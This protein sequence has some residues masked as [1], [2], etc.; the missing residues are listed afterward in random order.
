MKEG[1]LLLYPEKQMH[2]NFLRSAFLLL[3]SQRIFTGNSIDQRGGTADGLLI[4]LLETL[5]FIQ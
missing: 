3:K 5:F 2:R 4:F 1:Q